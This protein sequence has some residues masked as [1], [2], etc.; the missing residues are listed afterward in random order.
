MVVGVGVGLA[1]GVGAVLRV[2]AVLIFGMV[3]A[4]GGATVVGD[5]P[6]GC[7]PAITDLLLAAGG[8]CFLVAV[9]AAA[10]VAAA[11]AALAARV[12]CGV[13]GVSASNTEFEPVSE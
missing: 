8:V 10:A 4:G 3:K 9:E 5:G 12:L 13:I 11:A 6:K 7:W 1:L 2:W